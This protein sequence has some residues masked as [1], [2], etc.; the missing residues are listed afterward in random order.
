MRPVYCYADIHLLIQR[1]PDSKR[2]PTI[3]TME[4]ATVFDEKTLPSGNYR[5]A[6]VM[7]DIKNNKYLSQAASFRRE[8]YEH[9]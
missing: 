4:D 8:L 3:I 6:F 9:Y 5:S 2:K 7:T 1:I